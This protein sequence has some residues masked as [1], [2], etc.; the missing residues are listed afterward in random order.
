MTCLLFLRPC[1]I[2]R[3]FDPASFMKSLGVRG[4]LALYIA[5]TG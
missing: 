4:D 2:R 1:R 5:T 3:C